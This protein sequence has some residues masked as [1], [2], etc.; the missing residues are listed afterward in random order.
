MINKILTIFIAFT[1][2]SCASIKENM[3]KLERKP[4]TGENKTL[5]DVLC[6]K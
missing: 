6:K 5:A 4:C 1:F 3:P 2:V